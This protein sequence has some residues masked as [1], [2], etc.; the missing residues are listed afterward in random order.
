MED[1]LKK[2]PVDVF[3][4]DLSRLPDAQIDNLIDY[5]ISNKIV[6]SAKCTILK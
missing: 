3:K 5:A 4:K 6:D 1:M 2:K